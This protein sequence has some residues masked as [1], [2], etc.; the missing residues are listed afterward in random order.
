MADKISTAL[1]KC[2]TGWDSI[3]QSNDCYKYVP[4]KMNFEDA[5]AH[6]NSLGTDGHLASIHNKE[7]NDFIFQLSGGKTFGIFLSD[8]WHGVM[9]TR[10]RDRWSQI[11]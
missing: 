9:K 6:C 4:T 5:E 10:S 11:D 3:A 7:T 1:N 2:P 8:P